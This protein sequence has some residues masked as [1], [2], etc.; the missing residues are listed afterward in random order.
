ME[1]MYELITDC[2]TVCLK[3]TVTIRLVATKVVET[4]VVCA[5]ILSQI[6]MHI[7]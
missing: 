6:I 5:V 7:M 3:E 2:I 1:Q 4:C